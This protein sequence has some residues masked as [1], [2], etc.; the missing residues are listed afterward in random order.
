MLFLPLVMGFMF[1]G[2]S[3]G[4]VLYWLTGNVVGVVQQYFINRAM[5]TP[6]PAPVVSKPPAR[7]TVRK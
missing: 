6:A 2:V 7:R 4:L 3:S 1:Y 5:P